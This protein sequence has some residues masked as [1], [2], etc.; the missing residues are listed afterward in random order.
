M[1]RRHPLTDAARRRQPADWKVLVALRSLAALVSERPAPL[2]LMPP[3][4]VPDTAP[5]PV[6][7]QA[8]PWRV[9]GAFDRPSP[10]VQVVL[11][12]NPGLPGPLPRALQ[13]ARLAIQSSPIRR[14]RRSQSGTGSSGRAAAVA[15][16]P[17]SPAA[18]HAAASPLRSRTPQRS[19][20][21]PRDGLATPRAVPSAS[22]AAPSAPHRAQ[23]VRP[24]LQLVRPASPL[25]SDRSR[26]TPNTTSPQLPT[27]AVG[28]P[29]DRRSLLLPLVERSDIRVASVRVDGLCPGP[30]DEA[31]GSFSGGEE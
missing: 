14:T 3:W 4:A 22:A 23:P 27:T 24:A 10:A 30:C 11:P 25:P 9:V 18:P 31:R 12:P 2:A 26:P 28:L 1:T 6:A 7:D 20:E 13:L 15:P 17:F 19:S 16:P 5:S 29:S 21:A 8:T